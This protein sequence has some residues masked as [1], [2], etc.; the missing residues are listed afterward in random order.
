MGI[1]ESVLGVFA[2]VAEW[3]ATTIPTLLTMFYAENQ[4]TLLGVLA[5]AGLA[6][7]VAFLLLS[8]I[9]NF[10]HFRG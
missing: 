2:D 7:S 6:I 9:Q 10:L 8:I 1:L 5:V 4:L 3:I